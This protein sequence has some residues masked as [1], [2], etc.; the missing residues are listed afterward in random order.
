M[1]GSMKSSSFEVPKPTVHCVIAR[2]PL[3]RASSFQLG[4]ESG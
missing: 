2:L 3:D 1:Q 4:S